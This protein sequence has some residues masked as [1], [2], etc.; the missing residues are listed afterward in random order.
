M[1]TQKTYPSQ[2][3][4]PRETFQ[5][6]EPNKVVLQR[7]TKEKRRK[8]EERKQET[9]R[10]TQGTELTA[11]HRPMQNTEEAAKATQEHKEP[12]KVR[13][14]EQKSCSLVLLKC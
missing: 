13:L 4:F 3:S 7:D 2:V 12:N 11:Q 6:C 10:Q 9:E 8:R 5:G 1:A 14:Q